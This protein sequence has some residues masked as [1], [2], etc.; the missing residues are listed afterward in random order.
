MKRSPL[1]KVS[2]KMEKRLR[3][4]RKLKK[5]VLSHYTFCEMPDCHKRGFQVHHTR[6]RSGE[7]LCN[8]ATWMIVCREHHA[9]IHDHPNQARKLGYLKF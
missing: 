9:W 4:Y 2:K 8:T 1:R 3:E 7:N 5:D 6:G